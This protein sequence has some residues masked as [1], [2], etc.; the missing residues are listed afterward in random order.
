MEDE[1]EEGDLQVEDCK[2]RNDAILKTT[3]AV[4]HIIDGSLSSVDYESACKQLLKQHVQQQQCR[5][6]PKRRCGRRKTLDSS[7]IFPESVLCDSSD[8]FRQ[9]G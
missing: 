7:R 4:C 8:N 6:T 9:I 1:F 3:L 2:V 5:N